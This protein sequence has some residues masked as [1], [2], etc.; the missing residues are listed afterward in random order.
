MARS[1]SIIQKYCSYSLDSR[2]DIET[3]FRGQRN[4]VVI[5]SFGFNRSQQ[6][7]GVVPHSV[8]YAPKLFQSFLRDKDKEGKKN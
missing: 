7:N 5:R 3:H 4:E 6:T 2:R 1:L 8:A